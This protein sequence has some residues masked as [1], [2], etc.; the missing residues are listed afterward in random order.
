MT[1]RAWPD[2]CRALLASSVASAARLFPGRGEAAP[3]RVHS[4]RKTLKES[5][6]LARLF[7]K[8]VGE[9]ARITIASLAVIRRRVGQARDLDVIEARLERLESPPEVARPLGAAIARDRATARRAH[10]TLAARA[11]RTQLEAIAKRIEAL[12]LDDISDG[13]IVDAVAR[14]YH[15]ARQRGQVAFDSEDPAS[16]HALR[17]RVVDLRYQLA[18][19]SPAWPAALNAQADELNALRDTLGDFNDLRV[20]HKFAADRGGLSPDALAALTERVEAKQ[21]KLR[22]R[23]NIEFERLFA[24]STAAF[25]H[26]LAAYLKWPMKEPHASGRDRL[27]ER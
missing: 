15:Q 10:T 6:A 21:K 3:E 1:S 12:D 7:L 11:A 8:N 18:A 14:T 23:A 9:P 22:R 4:V 25:A 13:D 17:S 27:P 26:R 24:E 19:L 16:L 5:R 2:Y 20:L